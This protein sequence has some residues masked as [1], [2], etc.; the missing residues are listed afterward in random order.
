M[1]LDGEQHVG[2]TAEHVRANRLAFE[3]T[4]G[5]PPELALAGRDAEMVRPEGD[6]TFDETE[7]AFDGASDAG[8]GLGAKHRLFGRGRRRRGRG[9]GGRLRTGAGRLRLGRRC[10]SVC[11]S[12]L[13]VR[14]L[15][16]RGGRG[17]RRFAGGAFASLPL[18]RLIREHALDVGRR[19][20]KTGGAE[21]ADVRPLQIGQDETARI[22]RSDRQIAVA[23]R[24]VSE[25]I[26]RQKRPLVIAHGEVSARRLKH[27]KPV[28]YMNESSRM[29]ERRT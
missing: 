7:P 14:R 6:E 10:R 12:A 3:R 16:R 9:C 24:P 13:D 20:G 26:E 8:Q 27:R 17:A 28:C 23:A 4:D 2:E 22:G 25:S 18:L 15:R 5:D 1:A 21:K 11:R 19:I 29:P